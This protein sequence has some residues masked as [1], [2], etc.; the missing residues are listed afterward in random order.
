[1]RPISYRAI[2]AAA[3]FLACG[4]ATAASHAHSHGVLKSIS[5]DLPC[6]PLTCSVKGV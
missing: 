2:F 6:N 5:L 4:A 3:L 1:M